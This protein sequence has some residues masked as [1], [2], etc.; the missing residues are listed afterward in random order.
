MVIVCIQKYLKYDKIT[1][2]KCQKLLTKFLRRN[3]KMF[4]INSNQRLKPSLMFI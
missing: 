1:L 3:L 2:C 4:D